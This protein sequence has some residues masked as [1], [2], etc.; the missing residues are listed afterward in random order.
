MRER[1][2][3]CF[4]WKKTSNGMEQTSFHLM[5]HW[6]SFEWLDSV[7][8]YQPTIDSTQQGTNDTYLPTYLTFATLIHFCY[9]RKR[10]PM[11]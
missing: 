8:M 5:W 7:I 2:D 10:M 1:G 4:R 6:S 11:L 9:Y 3:Y